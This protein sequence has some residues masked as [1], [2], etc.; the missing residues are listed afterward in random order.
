MQSD[1]NQ[2]SHICRTY[3]LLN[4]SPSFFP[5]LRQVLK[6][7][8]ETGIFVNHLSSERMAGYNQRTNLENVICKSIYRQ[9]LFLLCLL[10]FFFKD[11]PVEQ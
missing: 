4:W 5:I 8:M 2:T 3:S 7:N 11:R 10:Y 1:W 9:V 6:G